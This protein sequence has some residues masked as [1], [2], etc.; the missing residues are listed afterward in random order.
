MVFHGVFVF[1]GHRHG[2]ILKG[3]GWA[4]NVH[5]F[6]GVANR[7]FRCAAGESTYLI[8]TYQQGDPFANEKVPGWQR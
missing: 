6:T 3:L 8:A 4:T 1:C 2:M 5:I 7:F